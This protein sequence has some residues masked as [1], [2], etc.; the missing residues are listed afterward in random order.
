VSRGVA[1]GEI[2]LGILTAFS[3]AG[4]FVVLMMRYRIK[5]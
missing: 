5:T 2:P 1:T 3:G 4:V